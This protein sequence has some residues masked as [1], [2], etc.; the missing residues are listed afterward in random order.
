[1]DDL[2]LLPI[3][4]YVSKRLVKPWVAGWVDNIVDIHPTKYLSILPH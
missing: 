4:H 2:P 1:M 3:Y